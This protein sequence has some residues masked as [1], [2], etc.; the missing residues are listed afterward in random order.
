MNTLIQL[1]VNAIIRQEG[2]P[3]TAHNPGNLVSAPWL[4]NPIPMQGGFW[5]PVSRAQGIAGLAHCVALRIAEG[6]T[7]TQLI[8]A[9]APSSD[10]NNTTVYIANVK[11]WCAI[12]DENTPLQNYLG[13]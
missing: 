2:E 3:A 12:P 13:A 8:S 7:L 6:E 4:P 1:I 9:W 11:A 10:G 5:Y